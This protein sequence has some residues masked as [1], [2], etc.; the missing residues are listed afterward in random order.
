[1]HV[2]KVDGVD[3][4]K[5][6][7]ADLALENVFYDEQTGLVLVSEEESAVSPTTGNAMKNIGFVEKNDNEK[8]DIVKFLVDSAKGIDAKITKEVNPMTEET[9]VVE[10]TTEVAKSEEVAPEAVAETSAVAEETE[11]A[12][13]ATSEESEK[14]DDASE[15][16]KA[17]HPDKETPAED[18]EEGPNAEMEEEMKAK[19]SDDVIVESIT[20]LKNTLTSAFSDLMSTVKSIQTEVEMLKSNKVDV[21]TVK[22]SLGEVAKDIASTRDVVNEFGKRVNAVEADTAFRKS[23]DLGEIVQEPSEMME[24]SLWGGRFLK[25]A[26]LFK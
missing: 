6:D 22:K 13:E 20:E 17:A 1:M 7:I 25:T 2:E 23:G 5:G 9:A 4:V 12:E 15:T 19:K 16:E 24:K 11:N 21:D 14:A 8:M 26:D 10:E 18:A 3:V